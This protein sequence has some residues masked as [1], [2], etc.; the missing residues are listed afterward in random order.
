MVTKKQRGPKQ[1]PRAVAREPHSNGADEAGAT[2]HRS[3]GDAAGAQRDAAEAQR[4]AAEGLRRCALE[5]WEDE[6]GYSSSLRAGAA[7]KARADRHV[8]LAAGAEVHPCKSEW[9]TNFVTLSRS[10]HR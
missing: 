7:A 2:A 1:V 3:Q 5:R 8:T 10:P 6:G 9:D 4:E